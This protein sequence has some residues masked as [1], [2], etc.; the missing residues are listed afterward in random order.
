MRNLVI[1]FFNTCKEK[2]VKMYINSSKSIK[3]FKLQQKIS[4]FLSHTGF[5]ISCYY[6][7]WPCRNIFYWKYKL[8]INII[9]IIKIFELPTQQK[10]KLILLNTGFS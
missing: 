3:I 6:S 10:I 4:F 1:N 9:T 8:S 7:F 2:N 5:K